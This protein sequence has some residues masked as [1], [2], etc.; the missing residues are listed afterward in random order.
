MKSTLKVKILMIITAIAFLFFFSN[1]F[2]L[3][4]VE[5]TS[6]ITAIAIDRES[7]E[8]LVT[9]QI[10][11]PEAIDTNSEN[12][13]TQL[14]GKGCTVGAAIKDFGDISGWF[15]KLAFCNLIILGNSLTDTNVIECLDYFAKTLRM[16]DSAL[17]ALSEKSAKDLLSISTPLDNISAFALQKIMLKTRGFDKDVASTDIKEFCSGHYS[18]N[19]S[20]YMPIIKTVPSGDDSESTSSSSNS[21]N[22]SQ[23][24]QSS[25]SSNKKQLFDA[26]TTALF[27]NGKMV[28]KL[29]EDLT[30]M[31]NALTSNFNGTTIPVKGVEHN[32]G[33]KSNY[34][35]SVI[36][37][38][39]KIEMSVD[40]KINLDISLSLYC[41]IIDHAVD[42]SKEAL[43]QNVK[44]PSELK[45]KTEKML[46]ENINELISTSIK[47]GCDF[48]RFSDKLYRHHH[49]HYNKFKD[50]YLDN[51]SLTVSVNVNGQ[52]M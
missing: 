11:V 5:K 50:N 7:D 34:L 29:N 16:Q 27:K 38:K 33:T 22:S 25:D 49:K 42:G 8:Y 28:G 14:S 41:Q 31:F 48:M 3:I 36:T 6:I 9:A 32:D 13:K 45:E 46:T 1:D 19:G 51:L 12:L 10:A 23:G 39:P 24:G 15:P 30:L 43:S 47:T 18:K 26:R 20:S 35:L 44:L 4:D 2:G 17:V 40:D 21:S 37:S 52:K